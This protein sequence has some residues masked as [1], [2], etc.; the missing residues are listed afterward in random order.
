[1]FCLFWGLFD[2]KS[3][4][5]MSKK[6]ILLF[7]K[8]KLVQFLICRQHLS[9]KLYS[10]SDNYRK[11]QS[12]GTNYMFR[13]QFGIKTSEVLSFLPRTVQ[14]L[15]KSIKNLLFWIF[16]PDISTALIDFKEFLY[17]CSV[18]DFMTR[19][20]K[21]VSHWKKI[22]WYKQSLRVFKN[23]KY[24]TSIIIFKR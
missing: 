13:W 11:F 16:I 19:S 10:Y 2:S 21:N 1:M 14:K 24:K 9:P 17:L 4:N 8:S 23:A 6:W 18:K 7:E 20:L 12:I 5:M 22:S 15:F 3:W